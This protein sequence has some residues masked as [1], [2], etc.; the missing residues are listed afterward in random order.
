MGVGFR[1]RAA[2]PLAFVLFVGALN[3]AG[4]SS[5]GGLGLFRPYTVDSDDTCGDYKTQL[6]SYRDFFFTSILVGAAAGA[7][8]GG[9]TGYLAGGSTKDTLLGAGLGGV[10][11]GVGGYFVA[12]QK[13]ANGN[14]TELTNSV[15]DDVK[16]ENSEIDG[17][18]QAFRKLRDCRIH[19]ARLVKSDL[20]QRRISHDDAASK[21]KEI[22]D[23]LEEDIDF[24]DALGAKM[25]ERGSEYADASGKLE[26]SPGA[27]RAVAR[28]KAPP[29]SASSDTGDSGSGTLVASEAVRVREQ[30]TTS[31]AQ[32]ASLSPGN[33]VT[34]ITDD[35]PTADWTHV[36][37]GDGRSGYVASRLLGPPGTGASGGG[38][39][40][41]D[42]AGVAQLTDSNQLKRRAL[43]D[44]IAQA[45]NEANGSTFELSGA[46]S[47]LRPAPVLRKAA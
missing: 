43:K 28:H 18:T 42:V 45:K 13:A 23:W 19:T 44:D 24:A 34:P 38:A 27:K 9:I 32:I 4:C 11:G 5:T 17:A 21:L 14:Q 8:V 3:I 10:V 47:R 25:D 36:Q 1:G 30:P 7:T 6:R 2:W 35:K 15:Y 31:S 39:P 26:S 22:H 29:S 16:K 33:S 41:K 20:A 40:P 12:K 37:L 46:I